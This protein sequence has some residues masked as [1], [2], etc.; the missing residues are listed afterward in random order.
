MS[1]ALALKRWQ[2]R[3]GQWSARTVA[4]YE[5]PVATNEDGYNSVNTR[6]LRGD[7]AGLTGGQLVPV[8]TTAS[9]QR[10][11]ATSVASSVSGNE[12]VVGGAGLPESAGRPI[13]DENGGDMM[14]TSFHHKFDSERRPYR[15]WGW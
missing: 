7:V 6:N 3:A 9:H 13:G 14:S 2:T 4:G 5:A 1:S 15:S 11:V 8:S 10:G 12:R